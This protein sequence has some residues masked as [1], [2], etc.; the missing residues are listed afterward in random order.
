M[1]WG[2]ALLMVLVKLAHQLELFAPVGQPDWLA[3]SGGLLFL[4]DCS[5]AA[6]P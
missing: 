3:V 5:W 1:P 6:S 4:L 2:F